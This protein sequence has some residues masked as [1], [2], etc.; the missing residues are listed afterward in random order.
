MSQ[1]IRRLLNPFRRW[2]LTSKITFVSVI[3]TAGALTLTLGLFQWQDWLTARGQ[4]AQNQLGFAVRMAEMSAYVS[5]NPNLAGRARAVFEEDRD[6]ISAT[7]FAPSGART[8]FFRPGGSP[9]PFAPIG[10]HMYQPSFM[11]SSRLVLHVPVIEDGQRRGELVMVS[12]L[13]RIF[14]RL[15][16]NMAIGIGLAT[17]SAILAAA[18]ARAMVKATLRPLDDLEQS[19]ARLSEVKDFSMRVEPRSEDE[20][21]RLTRDFNELLAELANYDAHLKGA[22]AELTAAR[23][24]AE[25]ASTSKSQFLANMSHEIRTPL[26]GVLGMAQVMAMNPLSA[27]QRERL[28]VI[29]KSGASLLSVLNDLLDI[30]KI[31]AGRMDLEK[32]PF[33]IE[34]VA[35]GAYATFTGVANAS[36]VSFSM[37]IAPQ[38]KGLWEGDSVRVR[39]ILYNLIS[40]A[41]KFTAEGHVE[42]R[43]D[44][45]EGA[46][47]KALLL[48][49]SD[50][51]IGIAPEV[52]ASI[53]EKF[54]QADNTTT[55]RFGGT[56]L[57]LTICRHLVE[58]IGGHI[59]VE[60][61]PG[62]GA[63][64]KVTL[65]LP[66]LGP[67]LQPLSPPAATDSDPQ[68][69]AGLDG[70]RVLAAED[71]VTNQLVMKT[72]LHSLGLSPVIVENGR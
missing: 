33:D 69:K 61:Q 24:E 2:S 56:G 42:V 15:C 38:A 19:M 18:A 47:G 64:F 25:E 21:G 55:R 48:S 51:G 68:A 10:A 40:N 41:L 31:E 17:I 66:W 46:A 4:L 27:P 23:N 62:A 8:D 12:G 53:F 26:N 30:S 14:A 50:T 6:A 35:Q 57:G 22:M 37:V 67:A 72:V 65:G 32:A 16:R 54:V 71:N 63:T 58:L 3:A 7:Y 49:V 5:L 43:I 28:E 45:A 36:G 39:Q 13:D 1:A 9:E 60:S 59:E 20:L 70:L 11:G 52:L 44:A 29:Q 34:E